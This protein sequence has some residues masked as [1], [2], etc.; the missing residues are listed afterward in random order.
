MDRLLIVFVKHPEIGKAKT[1][2]AASLGNEK[3]LFI[4]KQLLEHTK[5]IC[6]QVNADIQIF[7]TDEIIQDDI[8]NNFQKHQQSGTDLGER[9]FNALANNDYKQ[10]IIIGS[11]CFE[12]TPEHIEQAFNK[13][14][15][16]D[17]VLGPANDGGYYLFG[18]KDVTEELFRNITWSSEKVLEQTIQKINHLN[19][20][21]HLLET[22]V[23]IDTEDDLKNYKHYEQII[24]RDN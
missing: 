6:N 11:D 10:K 4:Y 21:H 24:S 12:I 8:W 17:T 20:S 23:D 22:L 2:L 15:N 9:M 14:E 13:L 7:Y 1:R 5:D 16:T 18:L 3:A 19:K